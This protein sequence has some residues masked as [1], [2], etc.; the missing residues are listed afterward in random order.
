M[1]NSKDDLCV[2]LC[3]EF[4]FLQ[5]FEFQL[6]TGEFGLLFTFHRLFKYLGSPIVKEIS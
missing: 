4:V 2:L 5:P 1:F 3:Q 6:H